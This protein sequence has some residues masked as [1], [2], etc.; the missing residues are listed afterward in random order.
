MAPLT[1]RSRK[2]AQAAVIGDADRL[3]DLPGDVLRQIVGLLP[4][5]EA[6]A[7]TWRDVWKATDRLLIT[8]ESAEEVGGFV[9]S[10]L[11]LRLRSLAQAR[12]SACEFHFHWFEEEN[13]DCDPG[14]VDRWI[15]HALGCE[16]EALRIHI[17]GGDDFLYISENPLVSGYL[18]RLQFA[19]LL[20][21]AGFLD[22]SGCPVLQDL[23]ICECGLDFVPKITSPSLKRLCIE[24]CW[25]DADRRLRIVAPRL[26]SLR[27]GRPVSG[28]TPVL[29]S[30]PELLVAHVVALSDRD[31]CYCD[32]SSLMMTAW[33][34]ITLWTTVKVLKDFLTMRT[35]AK[36]PV[37]G[38]FF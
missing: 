19:G 12:L 20:L 5:Q 9:D 10:L 34:A 13:E 4:A 1:R 28:R 36:T 38:V 3:S 26:V 21:S 33:A 29:E 7:R 25:F 27:L 2:K 32:D 37:V 15:R 16:I 35:K 6:V 18:K 24:Y 22:F 14:R 11:E 23:E 8:G 17:S 31:C 30:M